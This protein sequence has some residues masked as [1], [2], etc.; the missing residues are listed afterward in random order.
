MSDPMASLLVLIRPNLIKFASEAL[1]LQ[2][3][4]SPYAFLSSQQNIKTFVCCSL[5]K[6]PKSIFTQAD[7]DKV[8]KKKVEEME[9]NIKDKVSGDMFGSVKTI[10]KALLLAFIAATLT[11]IAY[12]EEM[13]LVQNYFLHL[14]FS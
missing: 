3:L 7:F 8:Q 10:G 4:R 6:K 13:L 11:Q 2:S 14:L 5:T 9:K 1:M 12:G